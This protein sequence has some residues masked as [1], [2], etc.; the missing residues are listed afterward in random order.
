MSILIIGLSIILL[1]VTSV[2][3]LITLA[4]I[5]DIFEEHIYNII[6]AAL[7]LGISLILLHVDTVFYYK[8][9]ASYALER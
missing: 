3:L 9:I 8:Y 2:S 4:F 5:V 6:P 1:A 7:F